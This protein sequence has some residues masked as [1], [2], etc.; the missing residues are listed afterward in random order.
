LDGTLV[1]SLPGAFFGGGGGGVS[2]VFAEPAYQQR[3]G[4]SASGRSVPDISALGDP[5]TGFLVGQTQQFST[6]APRYDEYRIGGTSVAAPLM[7]G[8]AAVADQ[9]HGS[10]LGFL[11]PRIYS[12]YS[13]GG[14]AYYDVDQ[15][16]LF[17][18]TVND[19]L[20]AVVRVNYANNEDT[21]AGLTYSLRTEEEPNQTLHSTK[22]YDTA[23]GVGT[24][25]GA[26]FFSAV[27][28]G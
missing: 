28:G 18:T 12:A 6:G 16:D 21:S 7:A 23:T 2:K 11:N 3:A 15:A 1:G 17:G 22:G 20:P 13:A 10:P 24:P 26:A 9:A 19:P 14:S 25:N 4:I 8:M 27:A 5:N